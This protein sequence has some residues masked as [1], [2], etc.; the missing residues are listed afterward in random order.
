MSTC[1]MIGIVA[2]I[3]CEI[4]IRVCIQN[5]PQL[6]KKF[7][8]LL[9]SLDVRVQTTT[10]TK[11][12]TFWSK[13]IFL[14]LLFACTLK[15]MKG[16]NHL[17]MSRSWWWDEYNFAVYMDGHNFDFLNFR[18]GDFEPPQFPLLHALHIIE[19]PLKQMFVGKNMYSYNLTQQNFRQKSFSVHLKQFLPYLH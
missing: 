4:C 7:Q 10:T 19:K 15:T 6:L 18:S 13:F 8:V 5:C 1:F 3:N 14:L 17:K 9:H 2:K 16:R 12:L 11:I